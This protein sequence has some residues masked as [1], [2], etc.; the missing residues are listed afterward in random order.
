[1]TRSETNA[2][3]LLPPDIKYPK[4]IRFHKTGGPE[5]LQ[6]DDMS[7]GRCNP[8]RFASID[9]IGL[10]R[11]EVV[12][13]EG[14]YVETPELPL[15]LGYEAA[16]VIE[17][18]AANVTGFAS[19]DPAARIPAFSMTHYG[20][21]GDFVV[22]PAS[23]MVKTPERPSS[24]NPPL[25]LRRRRTTGLPPAIVGKGHL[26]IARC[27]FFTLVTLELARL[28]KGQCPC[29]VCA[30]AGINILKRQKPFYG[31]IRKLRSKERPSLQPNSG[32]FFERPIF[33]P[34]GCGNEIS[35]SVFRKEPLN[36]RNVGMA[37][38]LG[39]LRP[40]SKR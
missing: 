7:A 27:L 15:L 39:W 13:R 24:N 2:Q 34:A 36:Y 8:A 19:G 16:G 30:R 17:E 33:R 14:R 29:E 21:N 22:L 23:V 9:A 20:A 1:V 40:N 5:V 38:E 31:L 18:V 11:A 3:D 4:L 32:R 26:Y 6:Y 28:A 10:N 35:Q 12:F 37:T 25:H